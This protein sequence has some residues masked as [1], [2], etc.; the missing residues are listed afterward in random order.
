MTLRSAKISV[1]NATAT[2]YV[3]RVYHWNSNS[4]LGKV[5]SA[6]WTVPG[7]STAGTLTV[8]F[9]TGPGSWLDT[10][11]WFVSLSPIGA[12][13]QSEWYVTQGFPSAPVSWKECQ[14]QSADANQTIVFTVSTT[15]LTL[16]LASG[17]CSTSM[18]SLGGSYS[19]ADF[20]VTNVFVLML[21]NH[22]FDN[23]F[24]ASG[25]SGILAANSND[26]NS[27]TSAGTTYTY[28]VTKPAPPTMS[29]DPGH[30]FADVVEQLAGAGKT[31]TA[32]H[33]YPTVNNSGFVSNYATTT[34]EGPV[35]AAS[36]VQDIMRVFDTQTQLPVIYTL[37]SQFAICD[38]WFSSM[39]GPTWPN[40]Y[41]AHGASSAG[42]DHSPSPT[43]I[44]E[45]ENGS[46]F[47][48]PNGSIYDRL[49]A[50]N[51][52]PV[53]NPYVNQWRIYGDLNGHVFGSFPQVCSIKGVSKLYANA[54]DEL[55][56]D[57]QYPY[58]YRYTFIEPNYGDIALGS[59]TGGNSQH[60]K[61]G[62]SA[63]EALIKSVYEAIRNSVLWNNSLLIVT[64]D[65]HGGFYDSVK[66]GGCVAPGDGGTNSNQNGFDF[67]QLGLRVPAVIVSP[68]ISAGTVVKTPFEHSSIPATIERWLGFGALTE[69][70]ANAADLSAI[71]SGTLRTDC[72]TTLP[73]PVPD[74]TEIKTAP[75]T[76]ALSAKA[77]EPIPQTGNF[78]GFLG[79]ALKTELEMARGNT[80]E[81]AAIIARFQALRTRGDAAAYLMSVD[82]KVKAYRAAHPKP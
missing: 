38:H 61:D 49:D 11:Y 31:Y 22:S 5:E 13:S 77:L 10:D 20:N 59:Y 35:P 41:F 25:I 76:E 44:V 40:R 1:K 48:Y 42:L 34:T 63:G 7:H 54:V 18:I 8:Q 56:S 43:E 15:T 32:G 19:L 17:G 70:D 3:I 30:E 4:L 47:T 14:L 53:P 73:D 62:V 33:S 27:Y 69:R 46:G 37:A 80:T 72:P 81:Q 58:P 57:L 28:K 82:S 66:P 6:S 65:E 16:G 2:E 71:L 78:P 60:P 74:T 67:T 51:P 21:E 50:L 39:P 23:I 26:T 55:A 64:Y 29:T 45:W 52:Y 24:A 79:V 68:W 12:A 75:T 9:Y 36:F